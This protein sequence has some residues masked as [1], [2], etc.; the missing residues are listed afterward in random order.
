M[1]QTLMLLIVLGVALS[2]AAGSRTG[3]CAVE[4]ARALSD[5]LALPPPP[6]SP[7]AADRT[8]R[9][10]GLATISDDLLPVRS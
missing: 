9:T 10:G 7:L 2:E 5:A 1:R 8:S 4:V 6:H 3:Q